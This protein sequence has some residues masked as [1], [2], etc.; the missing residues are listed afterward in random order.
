MHTSYTKRVPFL[1]YLT[2]RKRYNYNCSDYKSCNSYV[3]TPSVVFYLLPTF[4]LLPE[5]GFRKMSRKNVV[6]RFPLVTSVMLSSLRTASYS[7]LLRSTPFLGVE[8]LGLFFDVYNVS[9]RPII[10]QL[11]DSVHNVYKPTMQ[12]T[13]RLNEFTCLL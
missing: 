12:L 1:W 13:C 11:H 9:F 2:E 8:T 10:K 7:K 4:Y 6:P 5:T 3:M